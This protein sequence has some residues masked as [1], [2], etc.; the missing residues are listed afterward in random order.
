[1]EAFTASRE[2]LRE[3]FEKPDGQAVAKTYHDWMWNRKRVNPDY[4]LAESGGI[5]ARLL[6]FNETTHPLWDACQA[7]VYRA[8]PY[9]NTAIIADD[10]PPLKRRGRAATRFYVQLRRPPKT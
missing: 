7:V 8:A 5:E 3:V 1:M 6:Q 9:R 2:E 4:G 10:A